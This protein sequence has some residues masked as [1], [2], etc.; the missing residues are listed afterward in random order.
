MAAKTKSVDVSQLAK[1]LASM[2]AARKDDEVEWA[3]IC[4]FI[5][6]RKAD[7][8]TYTGKPDDTKIWNSV[9]QHAMDMLG[10]SLGGLITNPA[11]TWFNLAVR[12]VELEA[13]PEAKEWLEECRDR[14]LA[15]FNSDSSGFQQA[16]GEMY[17]DEAGLGNGV[18]FV[19]KD[20]PD[21][22]TGTSIGAMDYAP[23]RKG[24]QGQEKPK[25]NGAKM[26]RFPAPQSDTALFFRAI[27]IWEIYAGGDKNGRPA[28]IY[29]V[30]KMTLQQCWDTWGE[31]CSDTVKKGYLDDP[32]RKIEICHAVYPR[33]GTDKRSMRVATNLPFASVYYETDGAKLLEES[34][35]HEMPYM[36][37]R[38]SVISGK[39]YGRG[40]GHIALPFVRVLNAMSE[41]A[42]VAAEKLSDPPLMVPDDGFLGPV[43]SGP[44]GLSYYRS[45]TT[46][47]IR[48][49]PISVDIAAMDSMIQR[50]EDNVRGIFMLDKLEFQAVPNETATVA[51]A[52]QNEKMRLLGPVIGRCQSEFLGP[53]IMRV[54]NILR[55]AGELPPM[56][57]QLEQA[58]MAGGPQRNRL[59]IVYSGPMA[60]EQRSIE[61]QAL[62]RTLGVLAPLIGTDDPFGI[63][64]N[65]DTDDIVRWVHDKLGGS[66]GNLRTPDAVQAR[67]NQKAQAAQQS[68]DIAE[69]GAVVDAAQ[70]LGNTG[71]G[72]DTVLGQLAGAALPQGGFV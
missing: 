46:D 27:P 40:Q 65:F 24:W 64:D 56:P 52:R 22:D 9:P 67:R 63:M 21:M 4:R 35:Y 33:E 6:P 51:I 7:V 72:P 25:K 38:W 2:K 43:R 58:L 69:A 30:F 59:K 11:T 66:A 61:V 37:W 50:I 13:L 23:Q 53:L 1:R 28:H 18:L 48:P 57:Q 71:M 45:G 62:Q 44:G 17:Q 32:E 60:I 34:G 15:V 70:K 3:D 26:T 16:V 8:K 5:A 41:T 42:L 10:A 54:F 19:S 36:F 55:R 49:L 39:M 31:M 47:Q 29:R 20:G 12:Y 68:Q 14:M